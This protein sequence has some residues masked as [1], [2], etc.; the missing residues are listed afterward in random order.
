MTLERSHLNV[1]GEARA[2][3]P[4]TFRVRR[5]VRRAELNEAEQFISRSPNLTGG[6]PNECP[7]AQGHDT[8]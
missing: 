2:S 6:R 1:L 5:L 7:E 3:V 4:D 8:P